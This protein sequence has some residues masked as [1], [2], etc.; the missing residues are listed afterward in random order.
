MMIFRNVRPF[1]CQVEAIETV[2]WLTEVA[3]A[4]A[5]RRLYGKIWQHIHAANEKANPE[6]LR[7]ALKMATGS[8]KTRRHGH[9]DRVADCQRGALA[10]E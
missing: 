7:L 1:F 5:N 10:R 3:R 2:I 9:A 4:S 8:G 6:L